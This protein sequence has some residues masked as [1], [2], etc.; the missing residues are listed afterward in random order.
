LHSDLLAKR[1]GSFSQERIALGLRALANHHESWLRPVEEW[2][3]TGQ[4]VRP[5]FRALA[6]HLL[7]RYPVPDCMTCVWFWG[8]TDRLRQQQD[9]FKHLGLGQS[10]RTASIPLHYTKAMAHHFCQAPAHLCP[11]E[12]LRRGQVRGLGGSSALAVAICD[13]WLSYEFNNESFWTSVIHFF[14]NHPRLDFGHVDPI[15]NYLNEQKFEPREVMNAGG[16]LEQQGPANPNLSM[17]G[18][19]LRSIL[20][21]VAARQ[22]EKAMEARRTFRWSAS[23]IGGLRLA[24]TAPRDHNARLWTI[25]ELLCSQELRAEGQAMKHCVADYDRDCARRESRGWSLRVEG[26]KR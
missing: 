23:G 21:D 3:P 8:H 4:S 20:R 2:A 11:D 7:A 25:R 18:R 12:A 26:G 13:S 15:I 22:K 5:M 1:V 10:M 19:T 14:I 6:H 9:W 16:V 17:K 24:E